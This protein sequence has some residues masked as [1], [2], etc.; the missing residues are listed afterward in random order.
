MS[1]LVAVSNRVTIPKRLAAAGG[2]A[3]G[4]LA[5]MKSRGGLWF[6]W[7]GE[8]TGSEPAAAAITPRA[9]VT[10]ATID[11][12]RADFERYYGGH[13]NGTLWP[14]FH[15]FVGAVQYSDV[16]F[17]AYRRVNRLF[18]DRLLPLLRRDDL[19]WVHDYHLIPLARELRERGATQPLGF[20]LHVPFPHVEVLRTLPGY[21]TL[22]R[23]LL[24]YDLLGFQ[25]ARDRDCFRSATAEVLGAAA[26]RPDGA[27]Q[28]GRRRP[29]Q[30][31]AQQQ[32]Q[33]DAHA[34]MVGQ[35]LQGGN[36]ARARIRAWTRPV[37]G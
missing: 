31:Q 36:H 3:V 33:A 19:L 15:Y 1:R 11:L 32:G 14:L 20:F 12:P 21:Q 16:N 18:A 34:P 8:L 26:L 17:D 13:C 28:A 9:D 10:Y 30:Q 35:G 2:L 29:R 27:V 7:S 22:V 37:L 24:A 6:G 4:V 25:T 23:D 5:A